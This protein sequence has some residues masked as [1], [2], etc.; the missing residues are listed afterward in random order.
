MPKNDVEER[1][2]IIEILESEFKKFVSLSKSK[3]VI[4][5][6]KFQIKK[7]STIYWRLNACSSKKYLKNI[8]AKCYGS[9]SLQFY[10]KNGDLHLLV[11][12]PYY[13]KRKRFFL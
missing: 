2:K 4:N 8:M 12:A 1:K 6:Q 13:I 9:F 3:L 7:I 11:F 10:N 5:F